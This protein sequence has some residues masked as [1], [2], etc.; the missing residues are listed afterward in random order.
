MITGLPTAPPISGLGLLGPTL[1]TPAAASLALTLGA[2]TGTLASGTSSATFPA[3]TI[4]TAGLLDAP[5]AAIIDA[6]PVMPLA[7]A[8]K[9]G[10]Y[11]DLA[12]KPSQIFGISY[13]L[14]GGGLALTTGLK[15]FLIFTYS[16]TI[17]AWAAI[18]DASGTIA[19]DIWKANGGVPVLANSITG[20]NPPL[21]TAAQYSGLVTPVNWSTL[22]IIPGDVMGF[23]V[24]STGG[25]IQRV[26]L[27]LQ[28]THL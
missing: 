7:T 27:A 11:A 26:M 12:T 19:I 24:S 3:A 17:T 16:A 22:N 21:L 8:A 10:A 9:T 28:I 14:D 6:L 15:G 20:G 2:S 5:R 1:T 13:I 25:V 23:N 18:S 4:T